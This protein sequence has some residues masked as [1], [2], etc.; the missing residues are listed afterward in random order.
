LLRALV[1]L[2]AVLLVATV[3]VGGH[4]APARADTP[5]DTLYGEGGDAMTPVM[6]KLLADDGNQLSPEFGSYTNVDL[7]AGIADFIGSAPNTF[8]A[9]Y[10]VTE[11]P[12]TST[13]AA[14]AKADGRTYAYVPIA[15]LPVALVTLVPQPT[16]PGT[17]TINPTQFCQHIPL[18][19][20][21]L[22][23]IYGTSTPPVT[24]WGDP[25]IDCSVGS[26]AQPDAVPFTRWA[27]LDPTMENYA[28]MNYLDSTSAS[29]AIFQAGLTNGVNTKSA[30]TSSTTPS[31]YWPYTGSS[32]PGGD[33]AL[34]GKVIALNAKSNT[35]S[36]QTA[37]LSI[38]AIVPISSVWTGDPLG[39]AW[40]L[41]TA[42][43]QNAQGSYVIPSA[44]AAEASEADATLA[45]TTDPT[46]NNLV[47]FNASTSDAAAYNN[48]LMLES[49]LL[50]PTNGL[51]A[52]KALALAQFI[53]FALGGDGQKDIESLGAAGAT[54][55]MVTAGLQVAQQLDAEADASNATTTTTTAASSTTTTSVAGSTTTTASNAGTGNTDSDSSSDGGTSSGGLAFTGF[56]VFPLLGLGFLLFVSGEAARRLIRRRSARS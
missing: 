15:A 25:S 18:N 13:E 1:A 47:T 21:Q 3:G 16:F 2:V 4:V 31:E 45:S 19:L 6:I 50:V 12:L 41:P 32:I 34:L 38:G 27:N 36:T 5:A 14:T 40:N 20:I 48:Y 53:R 8:A 10:A 39:V 42:A 44:A 29:E 26:T 43:V 7:D 52:V 11:R 49:Y 35:P 23:D 46:T 28:L 56:A 33:E 54:P 30:L 9:D 37:Q 51:T 55:A 22:A 17:A 24:N